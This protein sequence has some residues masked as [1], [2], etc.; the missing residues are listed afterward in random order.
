MTDL[1]AIIRQAANKRKRKVLWDSHSWLSD[2]ESRN[3]RG[4]A[5][6][7]RSGRLT[8]SRNVDAGQLAA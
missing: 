7:A 8:T 6:T 5:E 3:L 4:I 2:F 1:P